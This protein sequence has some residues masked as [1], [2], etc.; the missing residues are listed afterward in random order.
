MHWVLSSAITPS[1]VEAERLNATAY[2]NDKLCSR[3]DGGKIGRQC[4]EQHVALALDLADVRLSDS[5][6]GGQL[7][8]RQ[9]G[10]PANTREIDHLSILLQRNITHKE[11][12]L[13]RHAGVHW[14]NPSIAHPQFSQFTSHFAA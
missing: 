1:Q 14:V 8:L 10:C 7:N 9:P 6:V 3:P 12:S 4:A 11:C 13:Q 2:V 5:E